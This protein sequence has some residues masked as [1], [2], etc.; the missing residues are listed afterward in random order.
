VLGKEREQKNALQVRAYT[1][2]NPARHT[3]R[4][5]DIAPRRGFRPTNQGIHVRT[6]YVG[7]QILPSQNLPPSRTT[8]RPSYEAML[9]FP[10]RVPRR[11]LGGVGFRSTSFCACLTRAVGGSHPCNTNTEPEICPWQRTIAD[12][13]APSRC[14]H[15]LRPDTRHLPGDKRR[16]PQASIDRVP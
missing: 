5:C 14:N 3:N 9:S 12:N 16:D 11:R 15:R 8:A 4:H 10:A 13:R 1:G 7:S 6:H 2:S